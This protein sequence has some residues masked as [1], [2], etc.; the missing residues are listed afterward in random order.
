MRE[1]KIMYIV[2]LC[3]KDLDCKLCLIDFF[4]IKCKFKYIVY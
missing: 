3:L 1:K 4:V 2:M